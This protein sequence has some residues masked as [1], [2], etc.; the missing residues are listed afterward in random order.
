MGKDGLKENEV[1]WNDGLIEMMDD[2][3]K[4]PTS[5]SKANG[6]KRKGDFSHLQGR[7]GGSRGIYTLA[8]GDARIR[9][10]QR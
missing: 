8:R 6:R 5:G 1:R 2:G 7:A 4:R 3:E 10:D 9:L